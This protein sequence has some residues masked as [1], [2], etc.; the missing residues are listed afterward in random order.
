MLG[1]EGLTYAGEGG[2][3]I[4]WGE[5]LTYLGHCNYDQNIMPT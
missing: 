4:C 5:G 2:A 3:D 1:R